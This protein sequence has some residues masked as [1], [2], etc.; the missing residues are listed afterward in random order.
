MVKPKKRKL[1]AATKSI[2]EKRRESVRQRNIE[3]KRR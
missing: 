3:S 1:K 2:Q